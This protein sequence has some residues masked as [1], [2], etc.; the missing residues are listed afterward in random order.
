MNVRKFGGSLVPIVQK[1]EHLV[2]NDDNSILDNC[3]SKVLFS[4]DGDKDVY[5]KRLKLES[6]SRELNVISNFKKSSNKSQFMFLDSQGARVL[7]VNATKTEYWSA[8]SSPQDKAKIQKLMNAVPELSIEE[9]IKC[10]SL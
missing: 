2:V 10:L 4:L 7:N 3:A 8:T 6:G 1:S 5:A 9:A